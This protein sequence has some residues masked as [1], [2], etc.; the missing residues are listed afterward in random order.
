MEQQPDQQRAAGAQPPLDN[1]N[2][3][4]GNV[5]LGVFWP[6]APALWFLQAE[7]QFLVK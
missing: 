3:A 7:C 2:N 4:G 1:V 5:K 6:H